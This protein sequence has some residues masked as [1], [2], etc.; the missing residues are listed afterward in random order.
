MRLLAGTAV[1]RILDDEVLHG[2]TR[3]LLV[4]IEA[5]AVNSGRVA[6]GPQD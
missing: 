5:S 3:D 2:L 6:V 1:P 4:P